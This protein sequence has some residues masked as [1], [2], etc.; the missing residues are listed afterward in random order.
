MTGPNPGRENSPQYINEALS[1]GFDCEIDL[2]V[3]D[4][5][6]KLGHNHGQYPID[7]DWMRERKENLWVHCKNHEAVAMMASDTL[8]WFFH[9]SDSY[10]LTSKGY[11]WSYPGVA[12]AGSTSIVLHFGRSDPTRRGDLAKAYG[13]CGDFVGGWGSAAVFLHR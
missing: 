9:D 6:T 4:G 2:W 5:V 7:L 13:I 10:T 11:V 1:A 3:C 8:N 12:V